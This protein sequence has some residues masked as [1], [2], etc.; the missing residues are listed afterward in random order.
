MFRLSQGAQTTAI[1]HSIVILEGGTKFNM[2]MFS[3]AYVLNDLNAET[4]NCKSN[5]L[6]GGP[7][8]GKAPISND[9]I[10]ASNGIT[11]FQQPTA[12]SIR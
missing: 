5:V 10:T 11:L 9:A 6:I 8:M 12:F 7:S 2:M 1:M 3:R 4:R